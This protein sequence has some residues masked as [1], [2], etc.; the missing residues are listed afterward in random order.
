MAVASVTS[1]AV[2]GPKG[3]P[4]LGNLPEFRR[5]GIIE[6]YYDLWRQ[7][8]DVTAV[9]LGPLQ[10]FSFVRPEH[11]QHIL[12]HHPEIYI[13]GMSHAKLRVAIGNGILTLEGERW[14]R[15]RKL[16]QPTY[17]PKGIRGFADLMIDEADKLLQRWDIDA[18]NETVVN[19]NLEM[20]RVTMSVISR[21]MFGIDIGENF[22]EAI[23]A[24]YELL[25]YTSNTTNSI[26]DTPLF[27][28]TPGNRRLKWAKR[29]IG[30][31]IYKIIA[32]RRQEGF[33]D[34]LL[35][36]LMSA[37]DE[38]TGEFMS[39]EQ[40]H[41]EVLITIFAGHETTASTLTWTLFMLAQHPEIEAKLHEELDRV[42]NGRSPTPEDFPNLPYTRMI[43]D[44]TLRLYSPVPVLARDTAAPDEIDGWSIPQGAMITLIP[45]ATHRHPDFWE[46][47]LEYYPEHFTPEAVAAR[48]RYAYLPFGSGQ[49]ICIG[50]HFAQMEAMLIL[51]DIAQHY[52]A[53]LAQPNDGAVRYIGVV[54]PLTPIM[55]RLE[56]R[57]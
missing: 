16:M 36:M 15:Q 31:F 17:T 27:I 42:L 9:R 43:L 25:E 52:R 21:A 54:R 14:Y 50:L 32:Q 28:P 29:T 30:D 11:I 38:A 22:R 8:G 3:V 35:S 1:K 39:D 24:L 4:V 7:Y 57:H 51:A 40:L 34:D 33:R 2:N 56:S 41:D 26:I 47:P 6:F 18:A 19:I 20:T 5:K 49:R 45:Y 53:R 23:V 13:K 12:V 37:K 10:A 46:K 48:P 55:M 44:E